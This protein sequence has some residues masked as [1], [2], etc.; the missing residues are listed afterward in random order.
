MSP[1][2]SQEHTSWS[3]SPALAPHL[4]RLRRCWWKRA[5]PQHAPSHPLSQPPGHCIGGAFLS[6]HLDSRHASRARARHLAPTFPP[7]AADQHPEPAFPSPKQSRD[8]RLAGRRRVFS[9]PKRQCPWRLAPA[10]LSGLAAPRVPARLYH[11]RVTPLSCE[12]L[13]VSAAWGPPLLSFPPTGTPF[14]H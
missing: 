5:W 3:F 14:V 7:R 8:C 13:G 11:T 1:R 6:P 2:S 9:H 4:Y 12:Q 10:Y